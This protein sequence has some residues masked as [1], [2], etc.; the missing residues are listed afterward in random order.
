M[1]LEMEEMM[2]NLILNEEIKTE[3]KCFISVSIYLYFI[4]Y[5]LTKLL[6][7]FHFAQVITLSVV[8]PSRKI[9]SK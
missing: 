8:Q 2:L 5:L 4:L 3:D 6:R 1:F 7:C 9:I